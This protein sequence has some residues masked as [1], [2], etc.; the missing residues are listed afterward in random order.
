MATDEEIRAKDVIPKLN[1]FREG[2]VIYGD[3]QTSFCMEHQYLANNV[4]EDS[5]NNTAATEADLVAGSTLPIMT[6]NGPKSLPGNAIA[7]ASEQAAITTYAQNVAHSIAPE[8]DPTRTS[9]NPYKAGE[10]VA[11]EGKTYT[12][13]VDHYGAWTAADVQQVPSVE[14]KLSKESALVKTASTTMDKYN[15]GLGNSTFFDGG[16]HVALPVKVGDILKVVP[17]SKTANGGNFAFVTSSYVPGDHTSGSIP[18]CSGTGRDVVNVSA[19]GTVVAPADAAYILFSTIDGGSNR[20]FWDIL[21][22]VEPTEFASLFDGKEIPKDY[23]VEN[24]SPD[25]FLV[26]SGIVGTSTI[27]INSGKHIAIPVYPGDTIKIK[28]SIS[29]NFLFVTSSYVPGDHTSGQVEF[30]IQNIGRDVASAGTSTEIT[31]GVDARYLILCVVDGG[32]NKVAWEIKKTISQQTGDKVLG[33]L[34]GHKCFVSLDALVTY[35]GGLSAS[36]TWF[37]GTNVSHKALPVMPGEKY[38]ISIPTN[39]GGSFAVV[40]SDYVPGD[41]TSGSVSFAGFATNRT[42]IN[43][44]TSIDVVVPADG[45]Y[46]I[47]TVHDGGNMGVVYSVKK[48]TLDPLNLGTFQKL[49][50]AHWNIGHFA[51]GTTDHTTITPE[52]KAEKQAAYRQ[53]INSVHPDVLGV[54]EDDPYFATDDTSSSSAVYSCFSQQHPGLKVSYVMNS[55]YSNGLKILQFSWQSFPEAIAAGYQFSEM[56]VEL[57]V[58]LVVMCETHLTWQ[59]YEKRTAQIQYLIDRYAPVKYVIIAADWN[60]GPNNGG[61]SEETEMAPLVAAGYRMSMMDYM[62]RESTYSGND[63]TPASDS[64]LDIICAKGF[65]LINAHVS[66]DCASLSDHRLVY[67]DLIKNP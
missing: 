3:G 6:A 66:Q 24:V 28:P 2:D 4:I 41:H 10:S 56:L 61:P 5:A 29:A 64:A 20:L 21:K 57:D 17:K 67:C 52:Q 51:M 9:E 36:G 48:W 49:R 15:G 37:T 7:K 1:K 39:Y 35:K 11:Y 32:G 18:F 42:V 59:N 8:F 27:W 33:L 16:Q 63:V 43:G 45:A 58:D 46:I 13:K 34:E 19:T 62:P 23:F 30:A 53:F 22:S 38:T 44:N 12:F 14:T 31:A 54:C 47:F 65:G 60:I 26:Y 55:I 40:T 25:Q 50:Y